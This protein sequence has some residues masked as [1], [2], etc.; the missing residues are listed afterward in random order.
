MR[1]SWNDKR[2]ARR[3]R[4][5]DR[6]LLK[7][8]RWWQLL[9]RSVLSISLEHDGRP[10][11]HTVEVRHGGDSNGVVRARLYL[12]GVLRLESRLPATFPVEGGQIEVRKRAGGLRRCHFVAHDG[13]TR[14]LMPD[15]RSAEGRRMRFARRHPVAS[16]LIGATSIA[17]LLIG[18]GLGALQ[19]AEPISET[20]VIAVTLGTFQ[21]PL[22]IPV[23]LNLCL[24][25]GA[26][27]ALLVRGSRTPLTRATGVRLR[28]GAHSRPATHRRVK[29][30]HPAARTCGARCGALRIDDGTISISTSTGSTATSATDENNSSCRRRTAA[31]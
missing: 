12:D 26:S 24:G 17:M 31:P 7:P 22:P 9:R 8:F 25:L 30:P 27:F 28:T 13:T 19:A 15:P 6:R 11:V 5:G 4:P 18:V 2:P 3:V 16:A 21:S 1:P 29:Q 10:I 14:R 23:W 20:T